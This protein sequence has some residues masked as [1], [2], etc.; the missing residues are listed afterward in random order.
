MGTRRLFLGQLGA[1]TLGRTACGFTLHP[2]PHSLLTDDPGRMPLDLWGWHTSPFYQ[3][4]ADRVASPDHLRKHAVEDSYKWGANLV[5]IYR[6]GYPLEQRA[7]WTR[8][9]TAAF[10]RAIHELDMLVQWFPHRLDGDAQP[11]AGLTNHW[12]S[13]SDV[14][15]NTFPGAMQA[16]RA[17]GALLFD[18]LEAPA[19]ELLDVLGTEQWPVMHA[20]L[21]NKCMWPYNPAVSFY[22]DN[23]AFDETLP[24]EIDVSAS[25]G[26]GTDDRTTGYY[27]LPL[28]IRKRY[29]LQFWGAQAEC[30]TGLSENRFGGLGQ[31][32]WVLKQVNDQCRERARARGNRLLSPS[33]MWWINEVEEMCPERN[34]S[35]VYGTSQDPVR[36]AV[37]ATL[38]SLGQGGLKVETEAGF[39]SLPARYPY[40]SRTAFLQNNYLCVFALPDQDRALLWRDPERLA[41]FDDGS[42]AALL[43]DPFARTTMAG[44]TPEVRSVEFEHVEPAG[45]RAVWRWRLRLGCDGREVEETRT[46]AMLSDTPYV[47]IKIERAARGGPVALG[48]Q[49]GFPRYDR[50]TLG[51]T[52]YHQAAELP[53]SPRLTLSDSSGGTPDLVLLLLA[54]G[55]LQRVRWVPKQALTFESEPGEREC[56]EL[57]MAVPEGLYEGSGIQ[58]LSRHLAEAEELVT[59]DGAGQ[60]I[61]KNPLGIPLVKVVR[62]AGAGPHPFQL[63]EFGRW[64]FRGAQPSAV[65]QGEDYLKCYLPA[66]GS[67]RIQRY[68]FLEGVARPGWGCQYTMAVRECWRQGTRAGATAVV[69]A[70]TSFLFAPRLRF[71]ERLAEVRV[72]GKPWRYF[73]GCHV[74]LPNRCGQYAI[75]AVYGEASQPHVARTFA[76]IESAEWRDGRL[77]FEA[78]LPEWMEGVPEDFQFVALVRHPGRQLTGLEHAR[79][80]RSKSAAASTVCFKPGKVL[81]QFAVQPGGPDVAAVDLDADIE[82]HLSHRSAVM[83][84]PYLSPFHPALVPLHGAGRGVLRRFDVL[85]WNHYCL[86]ALP[87]DLNPGAV[88]AIREYVLGGGG[89][90]LIANAIR[91]VPQ[92]TGTAAG[93]FRTLHIGHHLDISCRALGLEAAAADHPVLQGLQGPATGT[94]PLIVP[95]SADI[96]KRVLCDAPGGSVLATMHAASKPG[97][98]LDDPIFEPSPV[99]WEWHAG[100]G[101]IL[102]CGF[103]LRYALGS[104]NGW[105]PSANAL[106]LVGNAVRYLGRGAGDAK[107]GV[108]TSPPMDV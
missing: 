66:H 18:S 12:A 43:C 42:P 74:F 39:R 94:F 16:M 85:V 51:E 3:R 81:L 32:D 87:R 33:A 63:F 17:L 11:K 92:L 102:A 60:A 35:Y 38:A 57:A 90:F 56:F 45:Y 59:L 55:G 28:E 95:Q 7:G 36:C 47:R 24:N 93:R 22:T 97:Q 34:R 2:V 75:E 67:V 49:F 6:G 105:T 37:T 10:H 23:H 61:V 14:P 41:H 88:D 9:S 30:R 15:T 77:S 58:D 46:A 82:S 76:H 103:G 48:A 106:R 27:R 54:K 21:F 20:L 44:R 99:L 70:V 64:V 19:G 98:R 13:G 68:G 89:L 31:P 108:L 73:D 53:V 65:H 91:L 1:G 104:P 69:G 5:E 96:F 80:L 107:V 86:D 101:T 79:L 4:S 100:Q 40:P 62:V 26:F 84:R 29:G 52:V 78:R 72:N 83:L 50:L 71:R 25:N 8:E